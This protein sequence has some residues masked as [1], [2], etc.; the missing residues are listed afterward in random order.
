MFYSTFF[1]YT[2]G[3]L[4]ILGGKVKCLNSTLIWYF[5]NLSYSGVQ[6]NLVTIFVLGEFIL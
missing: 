5:L 2:Y 6:M 4:S 3:L 1:H